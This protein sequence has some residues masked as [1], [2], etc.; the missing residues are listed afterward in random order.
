MDIGNRL[1]WPLAAFLFLLA[2]AACASPPADDAGRKARVEALYAG[3][4]KDFPT[5]PEITADAAVALWKKGELL[6]IDVREPAERA[7]STLPGAVT[8]KEYLADPARFAGK[9]AVA[10]CTIGYRSGKW[11]E[12]KAKA[13]LPVANLAGGLLAWLH[14][15]GGLVDAK[16]DPTK[17]VHV[18]GRAWDLA[19]RGF[20]AVW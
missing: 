2:L 6:P 10:Y 9:T 14:A 8:E 7:V 16:G 11:A 17:T 15:G 13:G 12:A 1:P 3:Y 20:T 4:R 19:P 5:A 18:Y